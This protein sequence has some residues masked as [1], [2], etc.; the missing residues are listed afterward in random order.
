M[1]EHHVCDY[2]DQV[3]DGVVRFAVANKGPA[4]GDQQ[5]VYH[6]LGEQQK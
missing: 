4:N 6:N 5:W 1:T 2:D 3:L